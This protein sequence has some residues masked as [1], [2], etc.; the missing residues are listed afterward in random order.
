MPKFEHDIVFLSAIF[1]TKIAE[2]CDHNIDPR[3]PEACGLT[4]KV[5]ASSLALEVA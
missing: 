2:N 4:A 1:L 3:A 5:E